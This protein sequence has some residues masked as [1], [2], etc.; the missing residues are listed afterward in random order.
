M[1]A[2]DQKIVGKWGRVEAVSKRISTILLPLEFIWLIGTAFLAC[3][4]GFYSP[5][6]W[7]QL[8]EGKQLLQQGHLLTE[9]LRAFGFFRHPF[10]QDIS[11]YEGTIA[12]IQQYIGLGGLRCIFIVLAFLP[13]VFGFWVVRSRGMIN[14]STFFYFTCA[15][16]CLAPTIRMEPSLI[17]N[18]ALVSLGWF[19]LNEEKFRLS[20]HF[21]IPFLCMLFWANTH[22]SFIM[23]WFMMVCFWG[24]RWA[25]AFE[26]FEKEW[27]ETWPRALCQVVGLML[28][29]LLTT[30]G[31]YRFEDPFLSVSTKWELIFSA[32]L[33]PL[34]KSWWLILGFCMAWAGVSFWLRIVSKKHS[35]LLPVIAAACVWSFKDQN[36][37]HVLGSV[38]LVGG[39]AVSLGDLERLK[40]LPATPLFIVATFICVPLVFPVF[41]KFVSRLGG[42]TFNPPYTLA[43][44]GNTLTRLSSMVKSSEA[45]LSAPEVGSYANGNFSNLRPLLDTGFNRFTPE[46]IRYAHYINS[47]PRALKLALR[48]LRVNYV[49]IS[50]S[51]AH[52]IFVLDQ[53]PD[54]NLLFTEDDGIVYVRKAKDEELIKTLPPERWFTPLASMVAYEDKLSYLRELIVVN[55]MNPFALPFSLDWLSQFPEA[56]R[57]K[58]LKQITRSEDFRIRN[59][60]FRVL[61][62]YGLGDYQ[63]TISHARK[64]VNFLGAF[65]DEDLGLFLTLF[66]LD[67]NY[68]EWAKKSF[69][70]FCHAPAPSMMHYKLQARLGDST[71]PRENYWNQ[72][73]NRWMRSYSKKL[74]QRIRARDT[75]P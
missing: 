17:A 16:V 57:A 46:T 3:L 51:N 2:F 64:L 34:N 56:R 18:I 53:L 43:M 63:Q 28:G 69:A 55:W 71:V 9:P 48:K 4:I 25:L 70:L 22:V 37:L 52:W 67:S 49:V 36:H 62:S 8:G 59:T 15:L 10:P 20:F 23:G 26:N 58:L 5:D 31:L 30:R 38:M 11:F 39:L 35:W 33:W 12:F 42:A 1:S 66:F 54:W 47:D 24:T 60:P 75:S 44:A 14:E 19:L 32:A 68:P 45:F 27:K 7:W 72:K 40:R 13:F 65:S 73:S 50:Q 6:F 61:L 74:N 21:L 41:S 29:T